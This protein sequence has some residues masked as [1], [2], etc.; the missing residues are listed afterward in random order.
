MARKVLVTGATGFTG[1]FLTKELLKRGDQVR[2]LV[3]STS[4]LDNL[5]SE[6]EPVIG[7][8]ADGKLPTGVL[9]GVETIYHIAAVFR[10]EGLPRRY[11]YDV[12]VAG[13]EHLLCAALQAGVSRFV[14]CST[15]GVLGNIK[16]PPADEASPY[17][18]HDVYQQSK[19]EG[20]KLAM[21]FHQQHG[22]PVSVIRP[23][24]IYGPGDMRFLKLFRAIE[25]G[26]FLMIGKGENFYHLV[27]I[28]DL[29]DGIILAGERKEAIGEVFIIGGDRPI[30]IK[31]LVHEIATVLCRS[32]SRLRVPV[33]PVLLA[34]YGIQKS[35]SLF[36]L[37]PPLYPR[38]LDF[39]TSSRAFSI[40]KARRILGYEPKMAL[41]TGLSLTAEWYKEKNY[42]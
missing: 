27:Y 16:N 35:F 33:A 20:E 5:D 22:L 10:K 14:H 31:E 19:L 36:G 12:N 21:A 23:A 2:A 29:V 38:R 42:L 8:L 34:A 15:V 25:K 11:F 1:G 4:K 28:K 18:P 40:E 39:F 13:T 32:I 6:V 26:V 7:D 37:E 9:H 30:Q 24:A 17:A 3:R 41:N